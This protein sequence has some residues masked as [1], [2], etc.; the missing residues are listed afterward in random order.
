[1][2]M[3]MRKRYRTWTLLFVTAMVFLYGCAGTDSGET[4]RSASVQE[5]GGSEADRGASVQ[6]T[7][8]GGAER[9]ASVQDTD[10]TLPSEEEPS[11]IQIDF[12]AQ[13]T[14]GN[15]ITADVFAESKLTMVNVWATYCNPCLNE[16]PGLGELASEYDSEEFQIVGVISDVLEGDQEMLELAKDLIE[17][18][19]AGYTHCL[20][21]ESLYYALLADV[22]AVPTTYFID[23]NGVII[24]MV[25]GAMK[26]SDWEEKI[27]ALLEER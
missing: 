3:N 25:V 16:M 10:Q 5:A 20:L 6:E 18:T 19:G 7:D 15:I 22:T 8:G 26:K 23:E 24:D 17:Q 4:D 12:E 13:D 1:M 14:D 11:G 21:N 27:N 9:G 2:V